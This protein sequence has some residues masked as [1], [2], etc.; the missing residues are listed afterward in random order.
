MRFCNTDRNGK[1]RSGDHRIIHKFLLV[2]RRLKV[3]RDGPYETR[4]LE[5]SYITQFYGS[6]WWNDYWTPE[7]PKEVSQ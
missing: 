7:A 6:R 1:I 2:P 3:G 5:Y 4:W